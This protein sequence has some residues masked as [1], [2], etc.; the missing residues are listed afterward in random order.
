MR[1]LRSALAC[2]VLAGGT[3]VGGSVATAAPASAN[4]TCGWKVNS[5]AQIRENPS[6]NS[7]VRKTKYPGEVVTDGR[8]FCLEVRDSAGRFWHE[9]DCTCATDGYGYIIAWKLD[10][11]WPI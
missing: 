8:Q 11:L 3:A 5:E 4:G 7:V 1:R 6:I 9:V 10:K 2:L